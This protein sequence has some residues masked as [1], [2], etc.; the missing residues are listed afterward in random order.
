[1]G[2][3]TKKIGNFQAKVGR[4]DSQIGVVV[5]TIFAI[6]LFILGIGTIVAAFVPL[7]FGDDKSSDLACAKSEDCVNGEKCKDGKCVVDRKSRKKRHWWF[8]LVGLFMI[9]IGVL[10][11]LSSY[12]WNRMTKKSRT[13]AQVGGTMAEIGLL[14]N[15]FSNN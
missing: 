5:G 12:W 6:L 8:V 15:L 9:M 14:Q 1:M 2:N 7:S 3:I 11:F 13:I 4:I 10:I